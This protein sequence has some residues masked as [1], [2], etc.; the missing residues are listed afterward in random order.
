[1]LAAWRRYGRQG[2]AIVVVVDPGAQRRAALEASRSWAGV[3]LETQEM[4]RRGLLVVLALAGP[5]RRSQIRA[6]GPCTCTQQRSS[7]PLQ[8]RELRAGAPLIGELDQ[9]RDL[10]VAAVRDQRIVGVEFLAMPSGSK[11]RSVRSISCTW[12]CTVSRS[13]KQPGRVWAY[14]EPARALVLQHPGAKLRTLAR[15]ALQA[16][17]I[18]LDSFFMSEPTYIP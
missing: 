18:V 15:V 4:H 5:R 9:Q 6:R 8:L 14:G 16:E 7:T 11:I 12:Y 10:P 1:M 17:Q 3:Q 2:V 13:S